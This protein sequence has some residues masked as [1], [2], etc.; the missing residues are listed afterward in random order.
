[1]LEKKGFDST[2][3]LKMDGREATVHNHTR[4]VSTQQDEKE[5]EEKER[6]GGRGEEREGGGGIGKQ[7]REDMERRRRR[8]KKKEKKKNKSENKTEWI[9]KQLKSQLLKML[10]ESQFFCI[11]IL[12]AF[13]LIPI[14]S[15][16]KVDCQECRVENF[17]SIK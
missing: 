15:F 12:F 10:E 2:I 5:K 11:F 9:Y 16:R 17:S 7:E 8:R 14:G 6:Y 13:F 4:K 1:M 3:D